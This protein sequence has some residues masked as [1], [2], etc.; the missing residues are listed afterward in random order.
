MSFI[1]QRIPRD[2][3]Q[4][5]CDLIEAAEAAV[6]LISGYVDVKDG[7]DGQPI[8]NHAMRAVQTL[9]EAVMRAQG[10]SRRPR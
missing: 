1:S 9:Q 10:P 8:A 6:E 4:T 3:Y 2:D 7:P 5:I